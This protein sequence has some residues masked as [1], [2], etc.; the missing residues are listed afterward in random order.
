[1]PLPATTVFVVPS[2]RKL[3]ELGE[4]TA[5]MPVSHKERTALMPVSHK[6]RT[7]LM[8][9]SRKCRGSSRGLHHP[10]RKWQGGSLLLLACL[11]ALPHVSE[12]YVRSTHEGRYPYVWDTET[13]Q[14]VVWVRGSLLQR[15]LGASAVRVTD[16]RIRFIPAAW[17]LVE[18]G[19][20]GASSA[21]CVPDRR[22]LC[23]VSGHQHRDTMGVD[24]GSLVFPI[25]GNP[26]RVHGNT[27]HVCKY[28]NGRTS[29]ASDVAEPLYDISVCD[30]VDGPLDVLFVH[31]RVRFW[32]LRLL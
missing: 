2:G 8:P 6:E 27:T 26:V 15:V 20:V 32:G 4:R 19:G 14:P 10:K 24:M 1:M 13:Q 11:L 5:L 28:G 18:S 12:T 21:E 9:V 3:I 23:R 30:V 16:N 29:E 22:A 7:A 31:D 25:A 17:T